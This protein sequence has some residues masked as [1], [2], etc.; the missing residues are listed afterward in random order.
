MIRH[1]AAFLLVATTTAAAAPAVPS[2]RYALAAQTVMPHLDAM[3]NSVDHREIC[4]ADGALERLFPVLEHP[5]L[6]GC[7]LAYPKAEARGTRYVLSCT[8][9]RVAS[10]GLLLVDEG[11]ALVGDLAVKMGGKNMTFTQHVRA[12]RR[13][14]CEAAVAP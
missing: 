8:S 9:A 3:R 13:G 5:A 12:E 10:G 2:G 14:A 7:T 6:R 11:G 1:A 4:V